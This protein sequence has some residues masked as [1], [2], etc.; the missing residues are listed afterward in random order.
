MKRGRVRM[1]RTTTHEPDRAISCFELLQDVSSPE[2]LCERFYSSSTQQ[3]TTA[4]FLANTVNVLSCST[5]LRCFSGIHCCTVVGDGPS[6]RKGNG[7]NKRGG[8]K[9]GAVHV[10]IVKL[11][12]QSMR[13]T[14][15]V[16]QLYPKV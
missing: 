15:G 9:Q 14:Y 1:V 10:R 3:T 16:P 2:L 11:I 6:K 4:C 13:V 8:R 12:L 7:G 5:V